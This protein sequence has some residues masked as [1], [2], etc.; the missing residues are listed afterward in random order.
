[1]EI[2]KHTDL[3]CG[4]YFILVI[5]YLYTVTGNLFSCLKQQG[6]ILK[7]S[8]LNSFLTVLVLS[9]HTFAI[10]RHTIILVIDGARYSETL[11]DSTHAN[12]PNIFTFSKSGA[13]LTS[14]RTAAKGSIAENRT[15]TIPGHSR[16][17]TGTY[18]NIANDGSVFPDQPGIFQYYRMQTGSSASSSWVICSKDKLR[19]LANTSAPDW[20]DKY[21]P[22][23]NCGVNGDGTGGYRSDSLTNIIV[24]KKLTTDHP[25]LM[26]INY[27]GPDSMA[28]AN[29]WNGYI[30]AIKE[31]DGYVKQIWDTIQADSQM[32][33]TTA[34]FIVNDHGRHTTDYTSH[35]D[36][37]AGC[38]NIMCVA[39]GPD[40]KPNYRSSIPHEQI[41][42][43]PTIAQLMKFSVPTSQGKV[44]KEIINSPLEQKTIAPETESYPADID[45]F[46]ITKFYPTKTGTRE[47]NSAHWSNGYPRLVKYSSDPYD[48]TGW[49]DNHSSSSGDSLYIDGNGLLKLQ[50]GGPRFHIN[51]TEKYSSSVPVQ[52]VP[53][54]FFLNT[55]ATGYYKRLT[56]GGAAYDG[57]EIQV[58]TDPLGHGSNGG[59]DCDATGLAARFRDDGKWDFEKEL[60]HSGS[61]VYSTKYNYDAPLFAD[62]TIPLNK[63]IGMK[64]ITYNIENDKKVKLELYIDTVSDVSNGKAPL[65]GGHWELVGA[66]IDSG[67][68][69]PGADVSGCPDLT[70]NMAITT[71]HGTILMRTDN[72]T[73]VWTMVSIREIDV[74]STGNVNGFKLSRI[75]KVLPLIAIAKR[76]TLSLS[77]S[78]NHDMTVEIFTLAGAREF[79]GVLIAGSRLLKP[80]R[81]TPGLHIARLSGNENS[82]VIE[83]FSFSNY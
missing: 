22:S 31:I 82:G 54:Q 71:G 63:W 50:G 21:L 12:V 40:I 43:V 64:F 41:D 76:G 48:P 67:S 75:N 70:K 20:K 80:D 10:T 30:A 27:K 14:F 8:V 32:K 83:K 4:N 45:T 60:K 72:E 17:V 37:C 57:A 24:L 19:I 78:F 74:G 56:T 62:N 59:N 46:G 6:N 25:A 5:R 68:N 77:R 73:C 38:C 52:K 28:H 1:L 39:L 42:I 58:R 34:L 79:S 11:G 3:L 53:P 36:S 51:S 61:T 15:E 47:W 18:Q 9:L 44:I 13:T 35:G 29:N 65:N 81:L 55:E 66:M 23:M 16:I 7:K 49:T 33:N 2:R 69:W 26:I